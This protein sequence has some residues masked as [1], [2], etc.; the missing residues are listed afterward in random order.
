MK[1]S[2][3]NATTLILISLVAFSLLIACANP[4]SAEQEVIGNGGGFITVAIGGTNARTA[5]SWAN[6]LDSTQLT[7]TIT[8]SSGQGRSYT[9]DI[10]AGGGS[11]K[12]SVAPGQWN[13]LVEGK[14]SGEVVA[15]GKKDNVTIVRGDNGNISIQMEEPSGFPRL[16]VSF[17]S[18]GGSSVDSQTVNKYSKAVRPSPPPKKAGWGFVGWFRDNTTFNTKYDFNDAVTGGKNRL[19]F[20]RLE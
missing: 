7:H 4:M 10:P 20:C 6:T 12:F 3:K 5:V 11:A 1:N 9:K 15:V 19:Y 8:V 18:N 14:L 16:T 17:D 13:I 2:F